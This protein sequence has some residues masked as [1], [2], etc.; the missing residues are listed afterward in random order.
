S[1]ASGVRCQ[2]NCWYRTPDFGQF[3][4]IGLMSNGAEGRLTRGELEKLQRQRL[5]AMLDAIL[6][7]NSFYAKKISQSG[8]RVDRLHEPDVFARLPFTT[9]PE[10]VADQQAHPPYGS[11]LTFPI[12]HYTRMHQTSGTSGQPLRWL[13]T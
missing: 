3:I 12:G 7:G 6:P 11:N 4:R 5:R 2:I 8:L 13:D 10:L 9:K 1:P